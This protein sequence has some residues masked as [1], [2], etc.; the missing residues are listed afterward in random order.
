LLALGTWTWLTAGP[1]LAQ[2]ARDFDADLVRLQ[3]ESAPAPAGRLFVS[4]SRAR[5]ELTELP[6]GYFVIDSAASSATFVKPASGTY[7]EARRSSRLT[8]WFVPV[9]PADPCPRW[10]AMARI[11]GEP[12]RGAWH[13]EQDGQKTIGERHVI[14]YRAIAGAEQQF[15]AWVDPSLAFPVRI[16]LGDG[17][18]FALDAVKER[19]QAPNLT[20]IPSGFRKF[21]PQALIERIKQS[22]VWV[23]PR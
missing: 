20:Q 22:D 18:A 3:Q 23:E 16:E 21:D 10:Q 11:A 1:T 6:D 8:Q 17:T 7:M 13:C 5:L 19:P 15:L 12:D 4:A 2:D 9:D 14:G